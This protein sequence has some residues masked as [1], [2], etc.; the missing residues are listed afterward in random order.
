MG[1]VAEGREN[2]GVGTMSYTAKH[3][4]QNKAMRT[5]AIPALREVGWMPE[6]EPR[7]WTALAINA[8]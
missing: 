5:T 8:T 1:M 7:N 2:A 6:P 3:A 4:T